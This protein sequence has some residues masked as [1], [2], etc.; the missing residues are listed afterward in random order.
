MLFWKQYEKGVEF[1]E[2][3]VD[4]N[5]IVGQPKAIEDTI[6]QLKK[7]GLLWKW[8]MIWETIC[9]VKLDSTLI[10]QKHG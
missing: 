8:K 4:D 2:L 9:P 6:E 3:Y 1:L 10:K 5:Q 7:N